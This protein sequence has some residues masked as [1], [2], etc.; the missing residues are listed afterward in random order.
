MRFIKCV[1][2]DD[3]FLFV[4]L[5]FVVVFL[6]FFERSQTN[7][8]SLISFPWVQLLRELTVLSL[9]FSLNCNQEIWTASQAGQSSKRFQK[10]GHLFII[11]TN[12]HKP[13][14]WRLNVE[15]Q[16]IV[17][18]RCWGQTPVEIICRLRLHTTGN[19]LPFSLRELTAAQTCSR[20][21]CKNW[22]TVVYWQ[23]GNAEG[24]ASL[25]QP[26]RCVTG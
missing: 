21:L 8:K 12:V 9:C 18:S 6:L 22:H 16:V 10:V 13:L 26:T 15:R 25:P 17:R 5:F 23:A 24:D 2:S 4:R 14:R 19:K 11:V 7:W 20:D 1:Q 3:A